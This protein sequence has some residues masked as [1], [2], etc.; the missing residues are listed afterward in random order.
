[1]R[2]DH[3]VE[4]IFV[5]SD[6]DVTEPI[7]LSIG[8]G[9][10]SLMPFEVAGKCDIVGVRKAFSRFEIFGVIDKKEIAAGK[11]SCRRGNGAKGPYIFQSGRFV[12][13]SDHTVT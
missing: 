1:M 12:P 5:D 2:R 11:R 13:F 8:C 6:V 7:W 4:T 3:N 9:A 10:T